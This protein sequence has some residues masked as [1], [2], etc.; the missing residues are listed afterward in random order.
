M[1]VTKTYLWAVL[2]TNCNLRLYPLQSSKHCNVD[3]NEKTSTR[4]F[5]CAHCQ[6]F[7]N[8]K[9]SI[10]KVH[11]MFVNSSNSVF[12][13]VCF[14][15]PQSILFAYKR[16]KKLSRSGYSSNVC[17]R[18]VFHHQKKVQLSHCFSVFKIYCTANWSEHKCAICLSWIQY[19]ISEFC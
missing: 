2:S 15:I 8:H 10:Y 18:F 4:D 12:D 14:K 13:S 7:P 3:P 9:H 17:H 1:T 11:D 6:R 5:G 16:Y 19:F